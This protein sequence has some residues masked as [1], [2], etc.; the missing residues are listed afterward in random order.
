M[1]FIPE[2]LYDCDIIED[3]ICCH[4]HGDINPC[5][6]RILFEKEVYGDDE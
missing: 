4:Y 2:D 1:I 3:C 5:P 6:K